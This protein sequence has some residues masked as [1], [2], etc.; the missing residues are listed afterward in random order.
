MHA[1]QLGRKTW[2]GHKRKG[3]GMW[4]LNSAEVK[5]LML[6]GKVEPE[7]LSLLTKPCNF[8]LSAL[9]LRRMEQPDSDC[10]T[11]VCVSWIAL[12]S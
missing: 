12:L 10:V 9:H 11:V 5:E 1:A 8:Y 3:R 6:F 7:D 4:R 2:L